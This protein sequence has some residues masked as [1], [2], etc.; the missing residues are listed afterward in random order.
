M[1]RNFDSWTVFTVS[2]N[3]MRVVIMRVLLT[4]EVFNEEKESVMVQFTV[5][6]NVPSFDFHCIRIAA[7][8]NCLSLCGSLCAFVCVSKKGTTQ[9]PPLSS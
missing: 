9:P 6:S 5:S 1:P 4:L 7:D 3:G 8:V 2:H